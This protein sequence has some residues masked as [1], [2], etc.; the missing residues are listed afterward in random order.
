MCAQETLAA[1][2]MKAELNQAGVAAVGQDLLARLLHPQGH[3]CA[4]CVNEFGSEAAS[5]CTHCRID[6]KT[7]RAHSTV[8]I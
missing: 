4:S 7:V 5:K 2:T 3:A 1:R 8:S 6:A